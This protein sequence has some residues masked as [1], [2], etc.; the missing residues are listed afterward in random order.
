MPW[1]RSSAWGGEAERQGSGRVF[2]SGKPDVGHFLFHNAR[3]VAGNGGRVVAEPWPLHGFGH[4]AA[5]VLPA[6]SVLVFAP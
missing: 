2:D 5:L 6:N 4:S 3:V 1:T